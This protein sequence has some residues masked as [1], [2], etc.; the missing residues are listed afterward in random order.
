MLKNSE[1]TAT[2]DEWPLCPQC[3]TDNPPSARFCR[4]CG[5]EQP[6][7]RPSNDL[8]RTIVANDAV[9]Q[10]AALAQ[11]AIAQQA[12]A[13]QAAAPQAAAQQA[14]A[15]QAAAQQ[16]AALAPSFVE[17]SPLAG[18]KPSRSATLV[19]PSRPPDP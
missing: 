15:Q 12:A 8:G 6:G 13:Q 18:R 14:A 7:H 9:T 11:Q 10:Q 19:V 1:A 3:N 5:F 4:E 16:A 17:E 2:T